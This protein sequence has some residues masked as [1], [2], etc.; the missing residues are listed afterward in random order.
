M[1]FYKYV[2][3][4]RK[5]HKSTEDLSISLKYLPSCHSTNIH[6]INVKY[7]YM[8]PLK[9]YPYSVNIYHHVILHICILKML[10]KTKNKTNMNPLKV[11]SF[12]LNIYNNA[13]LQICILSMEKKSMNPPK[14]YPFLLNIYNN[15]ILQMCILSK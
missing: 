10:K 13:I 14:V 7:M 6:L 4:Q 5:V 3:Y 9:V 1:S 12:P 11:Y 2:S 8:N 15:V